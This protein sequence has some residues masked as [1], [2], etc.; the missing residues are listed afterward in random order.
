M[1]IT[2][3]NNIETFDNEFL[4]VTDLLKEKK[5]TFK[6]ITV[7]HNGHFI[8]KEDYDTTIIRDGDIVAA[9]HMLTGG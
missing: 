4:T 2:L 8:K 1:K 6:I 9:I 5:F 7:K 3:N